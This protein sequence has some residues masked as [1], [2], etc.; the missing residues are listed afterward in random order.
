MQYSVHRVVATVS[1]LP[2]EPFQTQEA[3]G[4]AGIVH[5]WAWLDE[6][7]IHALQ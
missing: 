6:A 7:E 1:G 3:V 2:A 5:E 4:D